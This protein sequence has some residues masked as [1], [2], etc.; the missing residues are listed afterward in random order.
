MMTR[1]EKIK[2]LDN[3]CDRWI[4]CSDGC[5]MKNLC[6]GTSYNC[7]WNEMTDNMLNKCLDIIRATNHKEQ[8]TNQSDSKSDMICH[9]AHYN[10]G[11]IECI[12]AMATATVNKH[13]IEAVCVS[14]VIK[15]LWRY[16]SK[17][18]LEDVKKAQF[19]LNRLVDELEAKSE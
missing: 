16:E 3:F 10:Q 15:Y 18:G 4:L 12:D 8:T 13:G 14:N 19:Y 17:N 9:P 6:D 5:P 11:N 1:E 2:T 7:E